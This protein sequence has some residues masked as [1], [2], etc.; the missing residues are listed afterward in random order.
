G[1]SASSNAT[2]STWLRCAAAT[3]PARRPAR[4][5]GAPGPR[6]GCGRAP[7]A[8]TRASACPFLPRRRPMQYLL[9]DLPYDYAAL[10]PHISGRIMQL[11]HDKHHRVYVDGANRA[12]EQIEEARQQH[13]FARL[14]ALERALAFNVSGHVLHSIFWKNLM[15]DGG[16]EPEGELA[17]AI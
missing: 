5:T 14:G 1:S 7:G 15:P 16:G 6:C 17:E 8:L 4:R 13:Q 9:P 12:I 11:H 3:E 10:E 2:R